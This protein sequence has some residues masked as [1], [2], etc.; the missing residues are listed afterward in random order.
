MGSLKRRVG[1]AMA[2]HLRLVK[3]GRAGQSPPEASQFLDQKL[4]LGGC[5]DC[6]EDYELDEVVCCHRCHKRGQFSRVED[7]HGYFE[8]CC[9]IRRVLCPDEH[10]P[11]HPGAA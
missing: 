10:G 7:K 3:G 2:K 5:S 4:N 6:R 11:H 9:S 8:V 1:R